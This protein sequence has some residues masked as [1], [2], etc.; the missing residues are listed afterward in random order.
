[1]AGSI[2]HAMQ[3]K[4]ERTFS[5]GLGVLASYTRSKSIDNSSYDFGIGVQDINNLRLERAV[6]DFDYPQRFSVGYVWALPIG[7]GRRLLSSAQGAAEVLLGGWETSG[8]VVMQ[9]G[10]PFTVRSGRDRANTGSGSQRPNRVSDGKIDN[11]TLDRWFDTNAFVMNDLYTWGNAGRNIL[12]G[13]GLEGWD[14]SMMKN[15]KI[16]EAVSVQFRFEFFNAFN[17]ADFSNPDTNL[18]SGNFGMVFGTR[19]SPRIGQ[20][21]LKLVF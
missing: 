3:V 6:S 13:D 4:F 11:P 2:Y 10:A 19:N 18:S 8:I 15:F 14:A 12:R 16:R 5:S 9:S 21:A 20:V 7:K 1:M 17:H